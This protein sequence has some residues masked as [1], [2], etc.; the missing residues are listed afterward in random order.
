M[1]ALGITLCCAGLW[2]WALG[3]TQHYSSCGSH[4]TASLIIPLPQE[5]QHR[6]RQCLLKG[7][8][9][10]QAHVAVKPSAGPHTGQSTKVPDPDQ[11]TI[12]RISGPVPVPSGNLQSQWVGVATSSPLLV[13]SGQN[14]TATLNM[15]KPRLR[16]PSHAEKKQ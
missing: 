7:R 10:K 2:L 16:A 4:E 15:C 6:Q 5:A 12:N 9:G 1:W 11:R 8:R 14:N 3:V 13:L